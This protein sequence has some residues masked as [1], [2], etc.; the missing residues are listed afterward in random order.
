MYVSC[1]EGHRHG[2]IYEFPL[3][4]SWVKIQLQWLRLL[5]RHG[6]NPC[7]AQWVKGSIIA[8]A[9]AQIQSLAHGT[10]ISPRERPLKKN[11]N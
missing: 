10:S 7:P 3:W 6:F 8:A 2:H 1:G 4:H 9:V 11:N 5:R